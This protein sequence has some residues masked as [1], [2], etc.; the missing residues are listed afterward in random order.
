MIRRVAYLCLQATRE[1]Q[2]S[3]AH[4]HE[5]INGLR[6]QGLTVD[7]FEPRA[8]GARP[9]PGLVRKLLGFLAVQL[10]LVCRLPGYD[11]LY[12]RGHF[13]EAPTV[14]AA[15]ILRVPQ[16]HEVNG[17]MEDLFVMYPWTRP[18]AGLFTALSRVQHHLADAIVTVTPQMA[19]WCA[20]EFRHRNVHV[21]PNGANTEYFH[22]GARHPGAPSGSYAIFFGAFSPWQG[23]DTMLAAVGRPEWP[24]G[25]RLVLAGD[26]TERPKVEAAA[27]SGDR[28]V[29]LGV[30]PYRDLGGYVASAA[31]GLCVKDDA[32]G[33]AGM[34]W[35]PLKLYEMMAA[36]V[37]VVVSRLAGQVE[38]VES[39]GAGLVVP[40]GDAA[41]LAE[42]VARLVQDPAG[43]RAMGQRGSERIVQAHSWDRRA[44]D[45]L[46]ILQG[47]ARGGGRP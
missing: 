39:A 5:I 3:H 38:V 7:L 34:G 25:T 17:P 1:G 40:P 14:L 13:A 47:V 2:A 37:P 11:A 33:H 23:I 19:E 20:G 24:P 27:A 29:Y 10:R 30:V 36:G 31:V 22:P 12:V 15:W 18:L 16:V 9:A 4:V 41:A 8:G 6:R 43:S 26:G 42:A 44:R 46:A 45:T 35:S 28:V 21:V 32:G